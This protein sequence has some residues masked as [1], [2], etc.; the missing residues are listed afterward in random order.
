[1]HT[2]GVQPSAWNVILPVREDV[3]VF[4]D[5]VTVTFPLPLPEA[6]ELASHPTS[7]PTDHDVFDV[8]LML[9]QPPAAAKFIVEGE[10][11]NE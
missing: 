8:T 10:I 4:C 11:D 9:F 1:M 7:A 3:E 5:A 6:V 2:C